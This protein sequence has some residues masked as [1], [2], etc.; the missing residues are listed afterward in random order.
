MTETAPEHPSVQTLLRSW[1]S[2]L[3]QVMEQI[4]KG[5]YVVAPSVFTHAQ[6]EDFMRELHWGLFRCMTRAGLW[7]ERWAAELLSSSWRHSQGPVEKD[8]T[9]GVEWHN[10]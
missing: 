1:D 10:R 2:D 4:Y 9:C 7:S 6:Q 3:L 5:E 8:Q